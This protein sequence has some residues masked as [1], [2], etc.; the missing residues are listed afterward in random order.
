MNLLH[1]IWKFSIVDFLH[2]YYI[3]QL[4][5]NCCF[6]V[7]ATHRQAEH[8]GGL[9]SAVPV[10]QQVL[11]RGEKRLPASKYIDDVYI[12]GC[13][14]VEESMRGCTAFY[15]T[16]LFWMFYWTDI[17]KNQNHQPPTWWSCRFVELST[18]D[19]TLHRMRLVQQPLEGS[20]GGIFSLGVITQLLA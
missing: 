13:L 9:T 18:V 5:L 10:R 17:N 14:C 2:E 7:V 4:N 11:R 20:T 8:P 15:K 3:W 1:M 6:H 12:S 16:L 19:Q